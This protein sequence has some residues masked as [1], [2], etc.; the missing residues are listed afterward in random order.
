MAITIRPVAEGEAQALR[1]VRLRALRDSPD[2]FTEPLVEAEA[3]PI[4]VYEERVAAS[5]RGE[6]LNLVAVDGTGRLVGLAGGIPWERRIRVVSVWV[7]PSAR[8]GGVGAELVERIAVWSTQ[9]GIDCQ[10]EIAP[11]NDPALRLYR[12]L[13]FE[14]TD[15]E[16]P[17]GCDVVLVR[18]AGSR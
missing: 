8:S 2:A 1:E 4:G 6:T 9:Q 17:P 14:P 16:P 13:G 12:R 11:G 15:D 18:P 5:V 10:I 3:H 7:D